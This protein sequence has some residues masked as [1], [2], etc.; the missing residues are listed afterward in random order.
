M[1]NKKTKRISRTKSQHT[2]AG[3][4]KLDGKSFHKLWH[5]SRQSFYEE[6]PTKELIALVF[7]W[8]KKTGY[9]NADINSAKKSVGYPGISSSTGLLC[10]L[11]KAGCPDHNPIHAEYMDSLPGTRALQPLSSYIKTA[12]ENSIASGSLIENE[13]EQKEE[14]PKAEVISIQQRMLEQVIP[15]MSEFEEILDNL[16]INKFDPYKMLLSSEIVKPA[17]A[18]IIKDQYASMLEEAKEVVAFEDEQIKEAYNHLSKNERKHLLMFYEKIDVACD[19]IINAGKAKRKPRK[20]KAVSKEKI[21][22]K[23]NYQTTNA[24][25]KVVSINPIDIL[26]ATELWVFNTKYRKIGKYVADSLFGELNIKGSTIINYDPTNSVQKTLRKPEEQLKQFNKSG[27][28]A[29]RKYLDEIT[30]KSA[31]LNGRINKDTILLKVI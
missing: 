13:I 2:F 26:G 22:S 4:E 17:H 30:S 29:L 28:V 18:K 21:I 11:L 6:S 3:W 12:I 24:E 23:L 1:R 14:K 5:D 25:F 16:D 10:K 7:D 31:P 27:K 20:A 8:M 15:L 9:S 19:M